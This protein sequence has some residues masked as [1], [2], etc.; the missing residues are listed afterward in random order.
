MEVND[1]ISILMLSA[2]ISLLISFPIIYFLYKLK[3]V[4]LID[5]DF[6]AIIESRR[7]KVGTP[8]M[9]GLIVV[10]AVLV[11]NLFLNLNGT[12][13]VPLVVF[14]V[15]AMLGAFD[16]VLNIYGRERSVRSVAR[17]LRLA[18]IHASPLMRVFYVITLPW[19][20]FRWIFYLLGSNPGKGIQSHEKIIIQVLVGALVGWWIYY[21]TGW[22]TPGEIWIPWL[23]S[24]NIGIFII[25]FIIFA[26]AATANAVNITDGMDGLS[27]GLLLTSFVGFMIV[28]MML[29]NLPITLLCA[30][31][32]GSLAIYLYFNIPPARF[33]MGDV[34]SL[35]L[36]ALL[37]VVAFALDR[38]ML[39][40]V[41]G[42]FFFA[43]LL[44][45]IIQGLARRLLGRRLLKMSPIHHHLEIIG[46]SEPKIVMRFWILSIFLIVIGVWLSQY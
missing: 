19:A 16:D 10:I 21:A 43:E 23:G 41:F 22:P 12:T 1:V 36:G 31:L 14:C 39:L 28:S 4:R 30:S 35:A 37:A 6:T 15:S 32:I 44:S 11:V 29:G 46:W 40:P 13:K 27:A 7:L 20:A 26:V 3:I 33:Q 42:F 34:G 25:P 38:I 24:I 17:T 9:G 2:L 45:V 5:S 18:K 8:L